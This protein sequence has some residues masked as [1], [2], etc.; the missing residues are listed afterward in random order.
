MQI[1]HKA[2]EEL[3]KKPKENS[4]SELATMYTY[5]YIYRLNELRRSELII[6]TGHLPEKFRVFLKTKF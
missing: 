5:I 4:Y 1:I 6:P 2:V 3:E